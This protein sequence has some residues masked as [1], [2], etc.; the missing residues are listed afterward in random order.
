MENFK[1]ASRIALRVETGKGA[2]S[3]EQLWQL[4]VEALDALAVSLEEKHKQSGKKSF[5]VAKSKK[6]KVAKLK[7]DVVLDILNV[8]VEERDALSS[9][10]ETKAHNQKIMDLIAEKK[11][12]AL[13]DL[14]I[15]ELE[16][17]L[18]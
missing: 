7:F 4:P 14:S 8:K 2:L 3:V 17:K 1:L 10:A 9:A 18:K 6:D 15:E 11:E 13:K 5:L 12:G 16:A